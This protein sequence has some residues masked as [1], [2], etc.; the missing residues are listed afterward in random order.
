MGW[1]SA[2]RGGSGGVSNRAGL[3]LEEG[4]HGDRMR[5]HDGP[6]Q[7]V[8]LALLGL[9]FPLV[10]SACGGDARGDGSTSNRPDGRFDAQL[11][12]GGLDDASRP[13]DADDDR[14][15]AKDV[16]IAGDEPRTD[17]GR[18]QCD[19]ATFDSCFD[20]GPH[21]LCVGGQCCVGEPTQASCRCGAIDGGCDLTDICCATV[22][23]RNEW[24]CAKPFEMS[25]RCRTTPI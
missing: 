5:R 24:I 1:G 21:A 20:F 6:G 16:V 18:P 12:E 11:P 14:V 3:L 9:A 15:G 8:H 22:E 19:P 7:A 17:G 2:T 23:D 25:E 13:G 10:T 4:R